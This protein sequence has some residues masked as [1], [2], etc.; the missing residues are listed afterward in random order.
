MAEA[1]QLSFL[2]AVALA[3][4]IGDQLGAVT[5]KWP[6]DVL[7]DEAKLAGIL[8]EASGGATL[9][10]VVIGIGVNLASAPDGLSYATTC[11]AAR[12]DTPPSP[13]AFL[14]RLASHLEVWIRRWE[15]LGFAPVRVAWLSRAG[16]LGR[17]MTVSVGERR[18][19]GAFA[20]LADD[21]ALMIETAD[22]VTS[23]HA[24]DVTLGR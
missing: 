18:T 13:T 1:G 11:L 6:N 8:L 21:G 19:V 10:A 5:L 17:P 20:G 12:G 24:G 7:L 16:R 14:G 22:G 9:D 23:I 15:S 4:T 2:T 3:E